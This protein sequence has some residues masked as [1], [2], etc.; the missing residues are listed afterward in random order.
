MIINLTCGFR[1]SF[2]HDES[3]RIV[4]LFTITT[5]SMW[6]AELQFSPHWQMQLLKTEVVP[7]PPPMKLHLEL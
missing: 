1:K 2:G 6:C 7:Q 4:G 5:A 3:L